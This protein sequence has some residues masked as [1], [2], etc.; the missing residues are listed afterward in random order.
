MK[1]QFDFVKRLEN[2]LRDMGVSQGELEEIKA[3]AVKMVQP[4]PITESY[5]SKTSQTK[6]EDEGHGIE[7]RTIDHY[8]QIQNEIKLL[9]KMQLDYEK[10][11]QQ[12]ENEKEKAV[13]YNSETRDRLL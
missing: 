13:Q 2:E 4:T 3:K 10:K 8:K 11:T 5:V 7:D 1:K 12:A 6:K 9:D